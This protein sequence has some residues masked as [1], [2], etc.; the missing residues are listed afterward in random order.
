MMTLIYIFLGGGLGSVARF[1][2]G[3]LFSQTSIYNFP[4]G[5]FIA[6]MLACLILAITV[7]L[8]NQKSSSSDWI[9]P[10]ILVGFCGGFST[11]ST[12]SNETIQL[13]NQGSWVIALANILLSIGVGVGIIFFVYY[14]SN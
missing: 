7:L 8:I 2:I 9:Q 13:L 4:M 3:R 6:N 5:T 14:R 10:L 1:G 11:F 12:F